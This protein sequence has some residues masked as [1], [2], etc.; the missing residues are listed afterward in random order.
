ME[1]IDKFRDTKI[2]Q[3]F[4]IAIL[5][6]AGK[7]PL[8][9]ME[10]CGTHTTAIARYGL[11]SILP[12]S[13]KLI[14]GP[15]CPVCVTSNE[16]LDIALSYAGMD[17][18]IVAC[19][20]DMFRVR[21]SY[22]SLEIE[23]S[24][25]ADVRIVYSPLNALEIAQDNPG[26]KVVFLGAGF[27]TTA[28][29]VAFTII[30]AQKR[31]IENYYVFSFH[32][33]VPSAL[34]YLLD[35]EDVRVDGFILPGHVSVITG[36]RVYDFI[37]RDYKVAGVVSGFEPVDILQSIYMLLMQIKDHSYKIENQYLRSVKDKGN[38]K[39]KKLV[40]KVFELTDAI[41]RG[42][43][44]ITRS[45]LKIR[46]EYSYFD[47]KKFIKVKIKSI[48]PKNCICGEIIKGVKSPG[49]CLLF[50]KLCTPLNPVGPCM[51]SSEGACAARYKYGS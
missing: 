30:A 13:I 42:L 1:Y 28:P 44:L 23:K 18:F 50:S 26:K 32:K 51:I 16:D 37:A 34:K 40:N 43:G 8:N 35:C 22:S 15:G 24:K 11:K 3:K 19:F 29:T 5:K 31:H 33:T 9:F 4:K 12:S 20:G 27:E 49:D 38:P 14:S 17:G 7:C 2:C 48:T 45:G 41:W 10:V 25:G 6:L 46:D 39:A 47:A 36:T 21:G